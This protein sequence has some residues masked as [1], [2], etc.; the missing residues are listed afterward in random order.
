MDGDGGGV[1][2]EGCAEAAGKVGAC[3]ALLVKTA[4]VS[5][6]RALLLVL[7]LAPVRF[8][9]PHTLPRCRGVGA[10]MLRLVPMAMISFG[11]YEVSRA[12]LVKL[13][14][15][16][17]EL[18]C[19]NIQRQCQPL[20]L[21]AGAGA[22]TGG[23]CDLQAPCMPCTAGGTGAGAGAEVAACAV[24]A[25]M[26]VVTSSCLSCPSGPVQT[27]GAGG[28]SGGG[29]GSVGVE[30]STFVATSCQQGGT[31]GLVVYCDAEA[32]AAGLCKQ[33]PAVGAVGGCQT[34]GGAA[35]AGGS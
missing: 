20:S 27:L 26:Q 3:M 16:R 34:C 17:V 25:P 10:C 23:A 11:T 6:S 22:G 1:L 28:S 30:G 7:I 14:E 21:G 15:L 12:A 8:T 33:Q 2:A 19:K 9:L 13:G 24:A 18:E 32:V 5:C 35:P 29:G 4:M 31:T